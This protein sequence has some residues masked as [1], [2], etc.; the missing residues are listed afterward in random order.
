[1]FRSISRAAWG[2][3]ASL[4]LAAAPGVAAEGTN[5]APQT[6][7]TQLS[8][9]ELANVKVATVYGAS[10]H[11]QSVTEAPSYVTII[12]QDDIKKFGYRTLKDILNSVPGFYTTSDGAYD[13]IGTRGFNRPGDY[14]GRFLI[15]IDG[16][17]MND[18]IFDSAA[19]GTEFL[20]GR[21]P[22]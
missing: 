8:F 10:K 19:I 14:G 5:A 3:A 13:Y 17:R 1:M 18:D 16:H 6:D 21:G 2:L 22:H 15:T 7:L 4:L 20:P 11:E 12:T 9:D